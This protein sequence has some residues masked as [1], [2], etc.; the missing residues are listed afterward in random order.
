MSP[1]RPA[2]PH[3]APLHLGRATEY[4]AAAKVTLDQQLPEAAVSNAVI[5]AIRASD[6]ICVARLRQ[7]WHGS[8]HQ[9]AA[10]LLALALP[11]EAAGA[12]LARLLRFKNRAQYG[13][14]DF[15]GQEAQEVLDRAAELVEMARLVV[16]EAAT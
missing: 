10:D 14:D 5:A 2:K 4:V 7:Q 12:M 8:D 13:V 16:A 9:G 6:A 1:A 3:H 15:S 11:D